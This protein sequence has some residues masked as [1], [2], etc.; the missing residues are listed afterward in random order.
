METLYIDQKNAYISTNGKQLVI[1]QNQP[2]ELTFSHVLTLPLSQMQ[3]LVITADCQ[4]STTSLHKLGQAGVSVLCINPRN[5]SASVVC[6]NG[7]HGNAYRRMAQYQLYTD[8]ARSL[9][10]ARILVKHKLHKHAVLIKNLAAH[11]PTQRFLLL[12]VAAEIQVLKHQAMQAGNMAQLLGYEGAAGKRFFEGFKETFDQH[13]G[14][15][16][17][18]RRPPKDPVNAILSL[19]YAMVHYE[20]V[21]AISGSGLD[22]QLGILHRIAYNRDS[23]ACDLVELFRMRINEWVWQQFKT[24]TFRPCHFKIEHTACL[25]SREG[26]QIFYAQFHN[27]MRIWRKAIRYY[28]HIYAR[29]LDKHYQEVAA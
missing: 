16:E 28:V 20:A 23:L 7:K 4:L 6:Y 29:Y 13:W 17:R 24:D 9:Q 2:S 3:S 27:Q 8:T 18:N 5:P 22:S 14:F 19:S 26:S 1:R 15:N 11:Y 10:L 21:L 25:L 12:K